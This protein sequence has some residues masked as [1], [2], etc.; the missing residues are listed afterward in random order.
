MALSH[1]LIPILIPVNWMVRY[2]HFAL[3]MWMPGVGVKVNKSV[4]KKLKHIIHKISLIYPNKVVSSHFFQEIHLSNTLT[5][6]GLLST[7]VSGNR[8]FR[9]N[10]LKHLLT[11]QCLSDLLEKNKWRSE[12]ME[13]SIYIVQNGIFSIKKVSNHKWPKKNVLLYYRIVLPARR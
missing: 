12:K 6:N 2:S 9:N 8:Q 5:W 7:A 3:T 10:I 4:N 13:V 11:G 1:C